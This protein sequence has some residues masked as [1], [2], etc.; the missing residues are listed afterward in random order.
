MKVERNPD[1]SINL[2]WPGTAI[3][4]KRSIVEHIAPGENYWNG[5]DE[6]LPSLAMMNIGLWVTI[7]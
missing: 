6:F 7:D 3:N 2:L 1:G 5:S 4:A